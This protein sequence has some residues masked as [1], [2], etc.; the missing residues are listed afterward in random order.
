M[1]IFNCCKKTPSRW[2]CFLPLIRSQFFIS[3]AISG[4]Q[5]LYEGFSLAELNCFF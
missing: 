2:V 5:I 1:F 4:V 3:H